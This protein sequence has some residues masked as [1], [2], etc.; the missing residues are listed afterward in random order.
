MGEQ[1][2]FRSIGERLWD[3]ERRLARVEARV[4]LLEPVVEVEKVRAHS[5]AAA[6]S[7]EPPQP[8]PADM[9]PPTPRPTPPP[10]PVAAVSQWRD[11][12]PLAVDYAPPPA[13]EP[14]PQT[15]L[16]QTIGLKWAGW[17]GAVVVVIG[18]G[19]GI[20]FAYEQGWFEILPPAGRL[21]LMSLAG[22]GL[23]G[24]GEYVFRRIHQL[25]AA[26]LFGAGVAT[27]FL[28]SYAGHGYYRLYEPQTAFVLMGL[29]TVI[30]AAVAVRGNLLSIA[31][32]S[33]IGGNLAPVLLHSDRPMVGSFLAYLL[34]LQAV[35]VVLAWWGGPGRWWTLRVMSLATT[36][37]W[38]AGLVANPRVDAAGALLTYSLLYATLYQAELILSAMRPR[39]AGQPDEAAEP[40]SMSLSASSP[41]AVAVTFSVAVTALLTAAILSIL[42][43]AGHGARGAWVLGLA[44]VCAALGAVLSRNRSANYPVHNLAV[45]FRVQAAALVVAAVPVALSGV[46][47]VF[48]WAVLSLTFAALGNLL[49][50]RISRWAGVMVWRLALLYLAGWTLRP[51]VEFA[52]GAVRDVGAHA[53]WLTLLGHDL[54]AYVVL[55]WMLA[56]VG[57]V[58]AWLINP[59]ASQ[60]ADAVPG[61]FRR[62]ARVTHG[63][64]GFIW[65][66]ASVAGLPPAGATLAIL[67]Y[68]WLLLAA[69][70]L[71]PRLG[72]AVQSAVMV[73]LVTVKWLAVDTLAER[74]APGWS[75]LAR[76]PVFNAVMGVGTLISATMGALYW[77]RRGRLWEAL[78]SRKAGARENDSA[79]AP[80]LALA[81]LLTTLF[82]IAFTF[83]IDRIVEAA[84][85]GP[86]LWPLWQL[87]MMAWT[88][89]WM[90]CLCGYLALSRRLEPD[91][92][93]RPG[94]VKAAEVLAVLVAVK[95]LLID[96]LLFRALAGAALST[97][98]VNFQT[99]TGAVVVGGMVLVGYLM[100]RG[101]A[102][103]AAASRGR[104]VFAVAGF[105]SILV[106]LWGGTL[107][108]DRFF[109][110]MIAAGSGAFADPRLAKQVAF[111]IFWSVFAV[112]AVLAGFRFRTKG[113]RYFGLGLFAVTLLK[114]VLLD[115]S[116][117]QTG[118][119][120]LSFLGLGLLLMGTS[121]VYGKLSP[122]LLRAKRDEPAGMIADG[123][124]PPIA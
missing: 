76:R 72:L 60:P 48:G 97:P 30:G 103:R 59:G 1:S 51:L 116:Q 80:A 94:W 3:L 58:I 120:V 113:L 65:F 40:L 22:F 18:A 92:D 78:T 110:R 14:V 20:K 108:L 45:G 44:G 49:N 102:D 87:K 90:L 27:L 62:L 47:I 33:Q 82:A 5:D 86:M 100:T 75:P 9:V 106:V 71:D 24:A 123:D 4:G 7:D 54:R 29:T 52:G 12:A 17:V 6:A 69:D 124:A 61:K 38:V 10:L 81:A 56:A 13:A 26:C 11:P 39:G 8:E 63:M 34:A 28:V 53:V 70:L 112:S 95:Y 107:E 50:L 115:M 121:V 64:A 83:E 99:L 16:E 15:Q 2:G 35:A 46:W 57:H 55:A 91:D 31:V 67:V 36:S 122:V 79:A 25:A 32:L 88:I 93:L 21:A 68:A 23:I 89:L 85:Q 41:S 101:P 109:E 77:L 111:S 105:L 118:Y 66:V 98:L 96:T 84:G 43:D 73:G 104:G 74:L 119:R 117:V 37:L 19:L 42:H 114:V